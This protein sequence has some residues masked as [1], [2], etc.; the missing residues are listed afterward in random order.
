MAES[1]QSNYGGATGGSSSQKKKGRKGIG[2]GPILAIV[3]V[4]VAIAAVVI[5]R[6][7]GIPGLSAD[8]SKGGGNPFSGDETVVKA[9]VGSEKKP[10]FDDPDVQKALAS[11]GFQVDV[12]TAGSRRMAN[13]T[14]LEAYDLAFPSS[15]PAAEKIAELMPWA[16]RYDVFYTPMAIATFDNILQALQRENVARET[17]GQWYIDMEALSKM[18]HDNVRWRDFA[19]SDYPSPRS[20]Q[21]STTDI[22]TSNSAAMYLALMSWIANDGAVVSNEAQVDSVFPQVTPLFT[23]QGYTES[24]SAGPF[25][26]YLSQ[27]VGSKPMVMVYESQYLGEDASPNSRLKDNMRLAYPSPTILSTHV[28]LGLSDDGAAVAKLLAEDPELQKLA[29]KHGYRSSQAEAM[30]EFPTQLK[31]GQQVSTD[32][33]DSI[34][35]PSFDMLEKLIDG[36]SQGYTGPPRP[37]TEEG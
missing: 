13:E 14:D 6:G 12:K 31:T 36:V 9:I 7:S 15:A 3:L 35:P 29:A 28:A 4:I 11:H 19:E 33:V 21:V 8:D 17:G 2:P 37:E 20:V 18:Q 16:E 25:S 1:S 32:F 10:F 27:G 22:R 24:S 23:G 34:D 30:Q 26:D 5:G